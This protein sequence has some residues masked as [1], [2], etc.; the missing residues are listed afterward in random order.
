[1]YSSNT[2][3]CAYL[4]E[5]EHR[6]GGALRR[7]D[8]PLAPNVLAQVADDHCNANTNNCVGITKINK[9]CASSQHLF[10]TRLIDRNFDFILKCE[11][12]VAKICEKRTKESTQKTRKVKV[13]K[14][15]IIYNNY[16]FTFSM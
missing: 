15:Y 12:S 4:G 14:W 1:M 13:K 6:L 2:Y 11:K 7:L 16:L 8:E 10:R 3:I 9:V 5:E